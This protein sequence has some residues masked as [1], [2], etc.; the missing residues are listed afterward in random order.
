[1]QGRYNAIS[2]VSGVNFVKVKQQLVISLR[3]KDIISKIMDLAW[4]IWNR[5]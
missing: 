2:I 5:Q 1:M 4:L 3:L